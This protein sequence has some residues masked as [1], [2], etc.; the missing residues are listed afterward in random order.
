[1]NTAP[2]TA[3]AICFSQVLKAIGPTDYVVALDERG[4]EVG[5]GGRGAGLGGH[6]PLRQ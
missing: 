3:C 5:Q 6:P 4:R 2:A 1:M